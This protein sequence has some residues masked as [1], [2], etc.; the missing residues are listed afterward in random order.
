MADLVLVR[1]RC[2]RPVNEG[3]LHPAVS[4][5]LYRQPEPFEIAAVSALRVRSSTSSSH[6][7]IRPRASRS[8]T[9]TLSAEA[10]SQRHESGHITLVAE[11]SGKLVG[12]L[13]LRE[14]CH[15]AMLFVQSSSSA[16]AS[17]GAA[18]G[19]EHASWRYG[20][21]VHGQLFTECRFG[22]RAFRFSCHWPEQCVHGISALCPCN[23]SQ[24]MTATP[25][26]HALERTATREENYKVE[27]RK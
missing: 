20:L 13:H 26:N 14:F 12:M 15:V 7:V 22:L 4:S 23:V 16:A 19:C 21:R 24:L 18:R 8:F 6:R 5:I 2:L 25:P 17:V 1:R 11:H 10:L 27:I 9:A 3:H